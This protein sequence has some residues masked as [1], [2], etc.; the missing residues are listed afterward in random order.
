MTEPTCCV[1]GRI[2]GDPDACGDCDP[3]VLGAKKVSEP[4]KKLILEKEDWRKRYANAMAQIDGLEK[5]P[6]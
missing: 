2:A 1:T 6:A 4:V 3:C 5:G